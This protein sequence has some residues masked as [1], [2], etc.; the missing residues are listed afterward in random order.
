MFPGEPGA[1]WGIQVS[2]RHPWTAGGW[3]DISKSD[4]GGNAAA[5]CPK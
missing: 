5:Y 2:A 3:R 4:E 1:G